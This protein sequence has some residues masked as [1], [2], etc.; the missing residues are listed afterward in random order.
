MQLLNKIHFLRIKVLPIL[1]KEVYPTIPDGFFNLIDDE[2]CFQLY[3]AGIFST[4][5]GCKTEIHQFVKFGGAFKKSQKLIFLKS[6]KCRKSCKI[7]D[8]LIRRLFVMEEEIRNIDQAADVILLIIS[9]EGFISDEIEYPSE[10][11]EA[12]LKLLEL[13]IIQNKSGE[14]IPAE[15]FNR[16][17]RWGIK[18]FEERKDEPSALEK[19][20][21]S[22]YTAGFVAG[23]AVAGLG[24]LIRISRK[25]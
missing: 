19:I 20:I 25:N 22:K 23:T 2:T 24:Y 10:F 16:A 7:A 9:N 17:L 5:P 18:K 13:R 12:Y 14:Y 21:R 11:Q 4:V 6:I 15:N 8:Y 1:V 3:L